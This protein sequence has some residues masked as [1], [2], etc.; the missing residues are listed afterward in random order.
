MAMPRGVLGVLAPL[1]DMRVVALSLN[2][3]VVPKW[4]GLLLC[5]TMACLDH[6]PLVLLLVQPQT[7]GQA[8]L[9]QCS[10]LPSGGTPH[11]VDSSGSY[12]EQLNAYSACHSELMIEY[13][14][15]GLQ[16]FDMLGSQ[17]VSVVP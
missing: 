3:R 14:M 7:V 6:K 11:V 15:D 12:C 1:W 16:L 4:L 17:K 9:Q 2:P 8:P 5:P 13:H 10:P